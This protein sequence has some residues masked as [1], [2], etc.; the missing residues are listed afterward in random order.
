MGAKKFLFGGDWNANGNRWDPQCPPRRAEVFMMN[1]MH[2]YGST[3]VTDWEATHFTNRNGAVS[4][5]LIDF[6]I[7][8]HEL[9]NGLEISTH[10]RTTSNHAVGCAPL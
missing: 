1:L 8:H 2:K 3:D 5:S 10:L 4:T 9:A 6:F 7:T